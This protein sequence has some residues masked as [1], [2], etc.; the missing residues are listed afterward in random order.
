MRFGARYLAGMK[1]P[2]RLNHPPEIKLPEDNRPLVAPIYQS[3]K[4]TFDSV[5]ESQRQ[6][7][8]ERD[9]F[10]WYCEN[11]GHK[12]YEEFAEITDIETQL[13]PIFDRFF[14][15]PANLRCSSCGT[16][17]DKPQPR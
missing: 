10:Q 17:M 14:G 8:G 9:G 1:H 3:V 5:E 2:T 12:L 6:S 11:C 13:P 4:F 16:V 7:R 15:N